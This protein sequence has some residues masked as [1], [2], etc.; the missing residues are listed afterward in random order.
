MFDP[1]LALALAAAAFAETWAAT[2][3]STGSTLARSGLAAATV[4]TLAVRRT[5]PTTTALGF[6]V[7]MTLESLLTESPDEVTVLIAAVVAAFS[8][9]AYARPREGILGLALVSMGIAFAVALDPSDDLS[10]VAPTLVLFA[11]LPGGFG[12]VVARRGEEVSD[13]SRR[14]AE[15]EAALEAQHRGA[16]PEAPA[17][18]MALT[19]R[20]RDVVLLVA[21]GF[22][23][24]EIAAALH[25]SENTIKGYVSEILAAHGLRDRTQLVIRAYESGLVR[26]PA[27]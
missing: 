6:G 14:V 26:A 2:E 12:L 10:N 15:A 7:G 19:D 13:L 8:V 11:L 3:A 18:T 5:S 9:T 20:Q 4:L 16:L 17:Q 1:L 23:N 25:L 24:R 27:V 21:R 22:A